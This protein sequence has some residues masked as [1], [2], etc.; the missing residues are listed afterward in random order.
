MDWGFMYLIDKSTPMPSHVKSWFIQYYIS[1]VT[2]PTA[3][4]TPKP[5]NQPS[6]SATPTPTK[7]PN[8]IP[9]NL[10]QQMLNKLNAPD[11]TVPAPT[12]IPDDIYNAT[13]N[14]YA[15]YMQNSGTPLPSNVQNWFMNYYVQQLTGNKPPA[16]GAPTPTPQPPDTRYFITIAFQY[17]EDLI[18]AELVRRGLNYDD[19]LQKVEVDK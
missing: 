17:R 5:S 3:T 16:S 4:L 9:A 11:K 2:L 14:W 10:W 6:A 15:S 8:A 18:Q 1:H 7:K 13:L 19:K 12:N